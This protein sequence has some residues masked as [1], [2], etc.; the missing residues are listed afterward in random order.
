MLN[1]K[2]EA[3]VRL[4]AA[5]GTQAPRLVV[6]MEG[7]L[8]QSQVLGESQ[9]LPMDKEVRDPNIFRVFCSLENKLRSQSLIVFAHFLTTVIQY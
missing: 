4:C 7:Q 5:A 9:K 6:A 3:C 8:E 1:C 2:G